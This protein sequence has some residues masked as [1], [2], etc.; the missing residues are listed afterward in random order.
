MTTTP[1]PAVFL[2]RDGVINESLSRNGVQVPPQTLDEFRILPGVPAALNK[3]RNAGYV[4]VVVTNQPDVARGTQDVSMIE[5]MHDYLR[6]QLDLDDIF[7]CTH[8]DADDCDCRKPR[9]GMIL[10]AMNK[11]QI[12]P[13]TSF[14]VG[15]R[16]K[17]ISAGCRAGCRT[18][19]VGQIEQG[20]MPDEPTIRLSDLSQVADWIIEQTLD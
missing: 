6:S 11:Y 14:M 15:D 9:P 5:R 8:D 3:L 16:W 10:S 17:D 4:L 18:V 12:E 7:V 2:D 20:T 13:A 19:L 1:R